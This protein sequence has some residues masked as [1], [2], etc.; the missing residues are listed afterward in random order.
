MLD[1]VVWRWAAEYAPFPVL[2]RGGECELMKIRLPIVAARARTAGS[3][4]PSPAAAQGVPYACPVSPTYFTANNGLAH[5]RAALKSGRIVILATGSS[6]IEGAGA[7]ARNLGYVPMLQGAL[8]RRFPGV[9]ITLINRGIGGETMRETV[10]RLEQD[11]ALAQPDLVIWQLG[12]NDVLRD[13]PSAD[14]LAEFQAA[15]AILDSAQT[16]VVLIDPQ[17]LPETTSHA[18]LK[19][20]NPA[21]GAVA[22]TV[23]QWASK[24]GYAVLHRFEAMRG[25][26]G[27]NTGGVG[28]DD[29]HLNDFGYACWAEITA[30]GLSGALR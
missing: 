4:M 14:M 15:R 25:W 30:E 7:S 12:T 2:G 27:I 24:S 9:A 16:D 8:Q 1:S 17:R 13:R 28:P 19:D 29:L 20:R 22:T 11:V 23:D 5:T 3:I 18:A 21:L 10:A 26:G 6:S